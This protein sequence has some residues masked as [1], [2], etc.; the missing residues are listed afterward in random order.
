M[1]E[2]KHYIAS[3]LVGKRLRFKCNCLIP[4]DIE[5]EILSYE[6]VNN[7]IVWSVSSKGKIYKFGENHP[8]MKITEL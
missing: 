2:F 6:I 5:G 8:N 4:I 1:M 3:R 7:E